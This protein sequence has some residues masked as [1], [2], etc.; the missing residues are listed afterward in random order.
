MADKLTINGATQEPHNILD[1]NKSA[2]RQKRKQD[3][4]VGDGG[5]FKYKKWVIFMGQP[6][7]G[8]YDG[9][10]I[11]K[12]E[13]EEISIM[14]GKLMLLGRGYINDKWYSDLMYYER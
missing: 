5:S 6:P 11:K 2:L 13:P 3:G 10:K 8:Y 1:A 9:M 4:F 7:I 14:P 12:E